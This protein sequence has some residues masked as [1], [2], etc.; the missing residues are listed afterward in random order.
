MRPGQKIFNLLKA[1]KGE[2]VPLS[3]LAA[4]LKLQPGD[5]LELCNRL[6]TIGKVSC[7]NQRNGSVYEM[8]YW[9]GMGLV[10]LCKEKGIE[11]PLPEFSGK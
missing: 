6:V 11:C 1:A 8:H 5:V 4:V 7:R 2:H 10:R 3:H 9:V